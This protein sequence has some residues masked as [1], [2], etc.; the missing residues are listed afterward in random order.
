MVCVAIA[1]HLC[2]FLGVT[3]AQAQD[4]SLTGLW[5]SQR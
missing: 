2:L 5:Q 3:T 1:F 4:T